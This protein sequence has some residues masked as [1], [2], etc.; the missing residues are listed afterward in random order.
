MDIV[1]SEI[2]FPSVKSTNFLFFI[3]KRKEKK[4]KEP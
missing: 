1:P 4:R 3:G 2:I